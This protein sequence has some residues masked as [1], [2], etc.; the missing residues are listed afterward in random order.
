MPLD[1]IADGIAG[2]AICTEAADSSCSTWAYCWS[3]RSA[4]PDTIGPM[5]TEQAKRQSP[6][7]AVVLSI[8]LSL[9]MIAVFGVP[10]IVAHF[11]MK[12]VQQRAAEAEQEQIRY[13]LLLLVREGEAEH[14][15]QILREMRDM[16][17]SFGANLEVYTGISDYTGN[18]NLDVARKLSLIRAASTVAAKAE[19]IG[20][21]RSEPDHVER[22]GNVVGMLADIDSTNGLG[23]EGRQ[24]KTA[25]EIIALSGDTYLKLDGHLERLIAFEH[26]DWTIRRR[27]RVEG[28]TLEEALNVVVDAVLRGVPL[29]DLVDEPLE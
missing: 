21:L 2:I 9:V 1:G 19:D 28:E 4:F 8:A 23:R 29:R 22:L 3:Q 15:D 5:N 6:S 17:G 7:K 20:Q 11:R 12:A 24:P 13:F 16:P 27:M 14:K 25:D 18:L 10:A 26:L